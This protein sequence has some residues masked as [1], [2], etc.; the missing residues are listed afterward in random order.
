[1]IIRFLCSVNWIDLH[2]N[3]CK[4]FKILTL[5][6]NSYVIYFKK[7]DGFGGQFMTRKVEFINEY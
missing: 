3:D 2:L 6:D 1:M 4:E 5:L 7:K